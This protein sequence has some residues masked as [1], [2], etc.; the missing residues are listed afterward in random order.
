MNPYNMQLMHLLLLSGLSSNLSCKILRLLFDA[1][2]QVIPDKSTD[3]Q[4]QWDF[5]SCNK[6][7]WHETAV[8]S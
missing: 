7:C 8:T 4:A 1:L 5:V 2:S 6:R 3:L